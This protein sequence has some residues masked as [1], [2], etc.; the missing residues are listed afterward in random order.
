MDIEIRQLTI[1]RRS[2][3]NGR[4]KP[5]GGFSE[6]GPNVRQILQREI[7][8]L[9]R[10]II[11]Q[12]MR[13]QAELEVGPRSKKTLSE[14]QVQQINQAVLMDRNLRQM[15]ESIDAEIAMA[16]EDEE[17]LEDEEEGNHTRY[18]Y[19]HDHRRLFTT[20]II[21]SRTGQFCRTVVQRVAH[22]PYL[23]LV[24]GGVQR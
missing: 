23:L 6:T 10:D 22:C 13:L 14:N 21:I 11:L 20:F 18:D 17:D 16:S 5:W 3:M 2:K 24:I 4:Q 9:S 1:K 8:F 12:H 15:L 7:K 19:S